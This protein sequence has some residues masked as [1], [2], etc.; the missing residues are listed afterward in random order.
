MSEAYGPAWVRVDLMVH[1]TTGE[2]HGVGGEYAP[3]D[4]ESD[5]PLVGLE[6]L[7]ARLAEAERERDW[8]IEMV[9]NVEADRRHEVITGGDLRCML[10]DEN[11]ARLLAERE[12]DCALKRLSRAKEDRDEQRQRAEK[13]EIALGT[14]QGRVSAYCASQCDKVERFKDGKRVACP[15]EKCPLHPSNKMEWE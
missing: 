12:R 9:D 6:I 10:Q 8:L 15:R 3:G 5:R 2:M 13:A 4:P 7:R 1:R 11:H 14:L